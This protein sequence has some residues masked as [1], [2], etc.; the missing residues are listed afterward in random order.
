MISVI[1]HAEGLLGWGGGVDFLKFYL[2]IF[3]QL[4]HIRT[5]LIIPY[6][7]VDQ[8]IIRT[9][10]DYIKR[11]VG[12]PVYNRCIYDTFWED[13]PNIQTQMY[14]RGST[15]SCLKEA[16]VIFLAMQ[17]VPEVERSKVIGYIPDLQHVYF[18][19][20]FTK[21]EICNRD[22][23]FIKMMEQCGTIL[24]NSLHTQRSLKKYY[25][26]PSSKCSFFSMKFLPLANNFSI[27]DT[28]IEKYE[29]PR[30]YFMFSN[31]LW[32]HKDLPTALRAMALLVQDEHYK[33]VELVCSG[34][35][36]D[37][38]NPDYF[39]QIKQLIWD[40]NISKNV[41][42]LGF[43]PKNEQLVIL[44]KSVSVV[45]TTLFEG[46]AGGGATYDAVAYGSSAIV[47]DI[48]VNLEIKNERVRFFKV[49][50]PED[51]CLK[52]KE[53]LMN[54]LEPLPIAILE[55]QREFNYSQAC[56]DIDRLITDVVRN[57]DKVLSI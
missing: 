40:L 51:L 25:P 49:G 41:R 31:Q 28:S 1:V 27:L 19:D 46:G 23:Q 38:R 3:N 16:D 57:N 35:T 18:P 32:V 29:L 8:K 47:S 30:R 10:K 7:Q 12:L 21:K 17:P 43:I 53:C 5:V 14:R 39:D 45:Q 55:E 48:E 11:V 13:Y 44:R 33:D 54:P 52:M 36:Y 6:D 20:F 24:V 4:K 15:P 50:D 34:A 26:V 9:V 22:E 42:F 56:L 37:Y 2:S